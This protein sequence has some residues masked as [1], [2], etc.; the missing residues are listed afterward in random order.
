[1]GFSKH[2]VP[3]SR[4]S[5]KF[6]ISVTGNSSTNI[7]AAQGAA[8]QIRVIGFVVF[9]SSALNTDTMLTIQCKD[10]SGGSQLFGAPSLI[11]SGFTGAATLTTVGAHS[12]TLPPFN[13]GWAELTANTA[14]NLAYSRTALSV[15]DDCTL[16]GIV[17][18]ELVEA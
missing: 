15:A 14:L 12:L 1:M 10:G 4:Q 18:W 6:A 11:P 8:F 2:A 5:T 7:V 16:D 13:G 3:G 9:A 17:L